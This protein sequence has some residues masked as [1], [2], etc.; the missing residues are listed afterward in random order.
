[1]KFNL[2]KLSCFIAIAFTLQ[3]CSKKDEQ[4]QSS[5]LTDKEKLMVKSWRLASITLSSTITGTIDIYSQLENCNKDDI[6][7]FNA[8]RT[9]YSDE[10][11]TKCNSQDPQLQLLG[12]WKII[13][14]GT[15]LETTETGSNSAEVSTI[16]SLTA[17][18]MVL[19]L[20]EVDP[21][22]G[23]SNITTRFVPR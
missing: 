2:L 4:P 15:Q 13:N 1:M 23:P 7:I 21:V 20:S 8:D 19:S 12:K 5:N 16:V 22:Y 11:P 9:Y 14:N 6:A 10:G 3:A 17:N 18:E